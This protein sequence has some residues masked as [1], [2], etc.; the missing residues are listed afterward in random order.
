M[1][2]SK[3]YNIIMEK[4]QKFSFTMGL[5]SFSI[6]DLCNRL[7]IPRALFSKYIKNKTELVEQLLEYKHQKFKAIF[8]EHNFEKVNSIKSLL[9]VNKELA[10]RYKDV[11]PAL[12]FDLQKFYPEIFEKAYEK[13]RIVV[14]EKILINLQ[15]GIDQ[16]MYRVEIDK[17][18]IAELYMARLIELHD[19]NNLPNDYSFA[20]IVA[21]I[22][23]FLIRGIA[24]QEGLEYYIKEKENFK[25][26]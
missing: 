11:S 8:E 12:A 4:L 21:F 24:T 20:E 18:L 7:C 26:I 9:I 23:D 10:L 17:N 5:R 1:N 22:I 19:P 2:I 16:G 3:E 25:I 6:N 15:K 14:K 13:D